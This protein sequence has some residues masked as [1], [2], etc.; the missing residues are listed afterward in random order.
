[1]K[2]MLF[3]ATV[4]VSLLAPFGAFAQLPGAG[5]VCVVA[6]DTGFGHAVN[7]Q[8]NS[9]PELCTQRDLV[10]KYLNQAS[11]NSQM[12][13]E[14][15]ALTSTNS[16]TILSEASKIGCNFIVALTI[17]HP[18]VAESEYQQK[19]TPAETSGVIDPYFPQP[20]PIAFTILR[21]KASNLWVSLPSGSYNPYK[22][23]A[24]DIATEV[25]KTI[26]K[27]PSP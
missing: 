14:A 16:D 27:N 22:W 5:K 15:V 10:V 8:V 9:N 2:R 18:A 23:S 20:A 12:K 11:T 4:V 26:L 19:A 25:H 7:H 6:R 3:P 17:N 21:P 24:K 1:M 13:L